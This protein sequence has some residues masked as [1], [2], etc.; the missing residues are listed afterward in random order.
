MS[1]PLSELNASR[2]LTTLITDDFLEA[3]GKLAA[4]Q[5]R[6][7]TRLGYGVENAEQPQ[8]KLKPLAQSTREKRQRLKQNGRL[9]DQTSPAKSNLTESGKLLDSI[10]FKV[11]GT[12]VEVFINGKRNQA[13][14]KYVSDARPF[15]NLS[16][17]NIKVLAAF[18]EAELN[19]RIK[20]GSV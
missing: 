6:T 8:Q 17:T 3:L 9:S 15:F 10:S 4:D 19:K 12:T 2:F 14:T 5:V 1:K 13:V 7:R 20:K 18:I 16:N 11:S